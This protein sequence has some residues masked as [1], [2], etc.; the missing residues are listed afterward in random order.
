[1]PGHRRQA[2]Q[3]QPPDG[4]L[5]RRPRSAGAAGRQGP[6]QETHGARLALPPRPRRAGRRGR[7]PRRPRRR[8]GWCDA[9]PREHRGDGRRRR[10][11]ATGVSRRRSG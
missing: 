11:R 9:E 4:I 6:R 3:V 8:S 5:R 7:G 1:M 10:V 2:R